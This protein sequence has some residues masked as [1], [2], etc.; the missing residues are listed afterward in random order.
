MTYLYKYHKNYPYVHLT[1]VI[2]FHHYKDLLIKRKTSFNLS[3]TLRRCA[4]SRCRIPLVSWNI[5]PVWR[6]CQVTAAVSSI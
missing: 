4:T 2:L 1:P 5:I 3:P 6:V